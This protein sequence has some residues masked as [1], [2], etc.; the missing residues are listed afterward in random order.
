MQSKCDNSISKTINFPNEATLE[1]VS[2]GYIKAWQWGCK[3]C[4]IYRDG[5]R[6]LQVLNLNIDGKDAKVEEQ[7]DAD[8]KD[9]EDVEQIEDRREPENYE[10]DLK[11]LEQV[12]VVI[13]Q[14]PS[15]PRAKNCSLCP[16]NVEMVRISGCYECLRCGNSLCEVK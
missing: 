16:T 10:F 4:T 9:T 3:G 8:A 5:S 1:E 7:T 12:E 15:P 14:K 2:D 13:S 6:I 11:E